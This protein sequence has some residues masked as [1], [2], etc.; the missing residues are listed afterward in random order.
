MDSRGTAAA[1]ADARRSLANLGHAALLRYSFSNVTKPLATLVRRQGRPGDLQKRQF[2]VT[3]HEQF[4]L[5]S[6]W[7]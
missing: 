6:Q 4:G 1:I 3:S 5:A 7:R 2:W